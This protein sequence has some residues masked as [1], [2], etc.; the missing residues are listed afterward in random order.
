VFDSVDGA[1]R[2]AVALQ[3]QVSSYEA[4]QPPDRRISFR[5]GINVGDAIPDGTDL[6][7]DVVN[8]AARLQAECPRG[9]ICV[10]RGVREHLRTR[11]DLAFEAL[12]LLNLKNITQ[13][14]EA[15]IVRPDAATIR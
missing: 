12:G 1:A 10:S 14:V 15:F 7:G 9:G 6:H 13:P 2:C 5:I 8:V 3:Q 4:D 11:L